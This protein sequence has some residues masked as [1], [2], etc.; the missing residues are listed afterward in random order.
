M[1]SRCQAL[2]GA[3]WRARAV[4]A[5]ALAPGARQSQH[6]RKAITPCVGPRCIQVGIVP[7]SEPHAYTHTDMGNGGSTG[8]GGGGGG[9]GDGGGTYTGYGGAQC[10]KSDIMRATNASNSLGDTS[11][12]GNQISAALNSGARWECSADNIKTDK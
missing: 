7:A 10:T 4:G 3:A 12:P 5:G 6:P 8:G 1:V 11:G 9:G 2:L